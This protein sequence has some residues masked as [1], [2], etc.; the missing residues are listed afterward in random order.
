MPAI[1]DNRNVEIHSALGSNALLFLRMT[2]SDGLSMLSEYRLDLLSEQADLRIDSLLGQDM[3]LLLDLPGGGVREFNGIVTRFVL[4]GRQGRY[5]S[6]QA[7]LRP[8]LWFLTRAADCCI[9]QEKSAVDIIKAIFDKYTMADYDL[10]NLS[11]S[12]PV[13]EYCVQYRE[14]DFQFV[15]RL[16]ERFGIYYYFRH[17]DGRHIL[18]LADSY[19]AH[20]AI[21][22]YGELAYVPDDEEAMRRS[23]VVY[24]WLAGGEIL[25]D[26]YALTA[27]DFER[28]ATKLLVKSRV[29]HTYDGA[30]HEVY[31]YPGPYVERAVGEA[32]AQVRVESLQAGYETVH[33]GAT[34]RGLAPGALF[35]LKEHAREDQNRELLMVSSE[36]R[37]YS[38]AYQSETGK[39]GNR[40]ELLFD[41]DFSAIGKEFTF[42]APR[43][44]PRPLVQGPQ[45]AIVVGKAGEEIWTDKYGRIKVQ[46]HWDRVGQDDESSSCWVR[47]AQGWAG[48]RWGQLYIPRIGQ[49][50]VVSFLEGDPDQ[51]LVTGSVYNADCMPPVTL[52]DQASRSTLK[53]NST[54]GGEG[55]N[56]LRFEDKKGSEQVFLHAEKNQDHYVKNDLLEWIGNNHHQMV[57]KDKM[58][59]VSGDKSSTV[60]GDLNEKVTGTVS[61][62]AGMDVQTKAGM[63]YGVD[64]GM[65]IHIK[66]GMNVVI[67]AGMSI[68]L[69]AGGGF[70]VIG[71][72][73]VAISGTPVLLNSGGAAGSGA[74]VSPKA[75]TAPDKAEDGST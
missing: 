11:A 16:M 34:V 29:A 70:I 28:P 36:Y 35:K 3:S 38:D 65:D 55:F 33:G 7:T 62:D 24:R 71:P 49:E 31:D 58:E 18:V 12:Y 5:A 10:G 57:E 20:E 6:Y 69:K 46:F 15:S 47:V 52:P 9:F 14:S 43:S 13:L 8:W 27:F 73:S 68:T 32:D 21:P 67:E 25:S 54:K 72:A 39:D 30:G 63:K 19:A 60:K 50:V 74:G 56:E 53:S 17:S 4:S 1:Q 37:L 41:C 75:P 59:Q 61:M 44:T 45:T 26:S 22:G 48:K 66:A 64:A 2:G 23:E 51:P 42:R 40:T